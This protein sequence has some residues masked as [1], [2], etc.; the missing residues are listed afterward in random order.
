M[1][2]GGGVFPMVGSLS[3]YFPGLQTLWGDVEGPYG[4]AAVADGFIELW[5][6]FEVLP[7]RLD[8]S[9]RPY[10]LGQGTYALRPELG[11]SLWY[12][13]RAQPRE[14]WLRAGIDIIESLQQNMRVRCGFAQMDDV[15]EMTLDR[16][17]PME[18]YF[19]AETLKYLYLLFDPEN[20][21]LAQGG[22]GKG[23][24]MNTEGHMYAKAVG[25]RLQSAVVTPMSVVE[26]ALVRAG[27]LTLPV[28]VGL[29]V[30]GMALVGV[31][32]LMTGE[33]AQG[34]VKAE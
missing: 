6:M 20:W 8:I 22:E 1:A 24:V 12:L 21:V 25:H 26:K 34:R 19:L 9:R 3:A 18:S 5:D 29:A 11:E 4:A 30:A 32:A 10:E 16:K 2:Q 33:R 15:Q 7:E 13:H 31:A 23:F 28:Q 17:L 14:K 27:R